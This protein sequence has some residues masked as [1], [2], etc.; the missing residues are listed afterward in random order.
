M[1]K[2]IA[3]IISL[4]FAVHLQ[5][6][7]RDFTSWMKK[8]D[9]DSYFQVLNNFDEDKN[10][11]AKGHWVTAV[12]GRWHKGNFEYRVKYGNSPAK[13]HA[14]YWL[15]NQDYSTFLEKSDEYHNGGFRLVYAQSFKSQ[16]GELR[17][18]GVWHKDDFE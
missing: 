2:T 8:S 1:K 7:E 13:R 4:F 9:L 5:A 10:F 3:L 15:I 14:W 6:N 12:E 17:Y 11:F 16:T 18:Q